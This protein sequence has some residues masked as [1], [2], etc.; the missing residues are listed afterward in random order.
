[1]LLW[2]CW[3]TYSAKGAIL[4]GVPWWQL[5]RGPHFK[6]SCQHTGRLQTP[7]KWCSWLKLCLAI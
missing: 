2:V 5:A 6:A 7:V 3:L 4:I 1:M